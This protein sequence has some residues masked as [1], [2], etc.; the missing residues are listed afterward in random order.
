MAIA[1]DFLPASGSVLETVTD[2]LSDA[3]ELVIDALGSSDAPAMGGRKLRRAI[4]V[5]LVVGAIVGVVLWR[6]SQSKPDLA[7]PAA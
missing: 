3:G 6:R 5:L 1:E 4:L 7:E 2:A